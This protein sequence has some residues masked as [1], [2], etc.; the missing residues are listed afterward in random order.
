MSLLRY[1][2]QYI[3]PY[4]HVSPLVCNFERVKKN[5]KQL[6]FYEATHYLKKMTTIVIN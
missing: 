1:F 4:F 6:I 5:K 3:L 2:S